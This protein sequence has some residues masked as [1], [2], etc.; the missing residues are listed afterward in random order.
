[1]DQSEDTAQDK[2]AA[3]QLSIDQLLEQIRAEARYLEQEEGLSM[4]VDKVP[5]PLRELPVWEYQPEPF[6]VRAVYHV[7]EFL[8]YDDIEFV[9][10]AF[11][12]ILQ[13]E[14]DETGLDGYTRLLRR[15]GDKVKVTALIDLLESDEGRARNVRV[16]GMRW[17]RWEHRFRD[18]WWFKRPTIRTLYDIAK[19]R[20]RN[21]QLDY[22]LVNDRRQR[23]ASERASKYLAEQHQ[24][25]DYMRQREQ[26]IEAQ[27]ETLQH[28]LERYRRETQLARQDLL[29]QQQ[30]V[31][32]LLDKLKEAG[33]EDASAVKAELS[34]FADDK[35]DAFYLAFENECRGDEADIKQQLAVYLPRLEQATLTLETPLL[36]IGSG[37]GEWLSL[38]KE[39]QVPA[40]GVDVSPV[41]VN[42][43]RQRELAVTLADAIEYLVGLETSSLGAITSFHVIEHLP[44][45]QL[46]T[47][48]EQCHRVLSPGGVLIFETPN[49]EN[50][51]VGSHTFYHDPTHRNPITPTMIDFLL[52][53]LG[54]V[55]VELERLHPYPEDARVAGLDALTDR[56]NGAFCGPQDFAVIGT[57][58]A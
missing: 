53:H 28:K 32:L 22:S 44:F 4:A 18:K 54:F 25:F 5:L 13:R 16:M 48:V 1:M 47:L 15:H 55:D 52:R 46:Y 20:L 6:P 27:H 56:V 21:D 26:Q 29:I 38:L 39:K 58:P 12:G 37:R 30:R 14:P 50:M 9:V 10:N 11:R 33:V 34:A 19:Y 36:D 51:N 7:N 40:C 23:L 49:P 43:C 41:L 57:K 24:L 2:A 42:H 35:L 3:Q 45:D 31:N 8:V 17:E